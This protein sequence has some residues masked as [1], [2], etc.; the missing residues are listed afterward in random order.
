MPGS[1]KDS[2]ECFLGGNSCKRWRLPPAWPQWEVVWG[3]LGR[4]AAQQK[5]SQADILRFDPLGTVT[6][7][8]VTDIHAQLMPVYFREPS[9]NLGVGEV[10]GLPPHLTDAEPS[11]L[12]S[13]SP[14]GSADAHALTSDDFVQLAQ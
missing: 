11:G 10:K 14:P 13:R 6:I 7:L 2:T 9:I 3:L 1:F 12:I 8:H 4:A 5:L